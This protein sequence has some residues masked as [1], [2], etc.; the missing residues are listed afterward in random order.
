MNFTFGIVSNGKNYEHLNKCLE[1]IIN[2]KIK[3]SEIIVVGNLNKNEIVDNMKI[4]FIDFD[5]NIKPGWITRKK[6]IITENSKYENI[7]YLHDYLTF[8]KNWYKGFT[9]FGNNFEIS[10]NKILNPNNTRYRDWTLWPHND[11]FMDEIIDDNACLIPYRI[12]NLTEYMYI[13]GAYWVAKKEI[14][15]EFPLN[16]NLTWGEG[17]DVEWSKQVR[18]KYEFKFN[19]YSIVKLQK[20]KNPQFKKI[21]RAQLRSI[22]KQIN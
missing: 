15:K 16:E 9:K 11:C 2:Q 20:Y 13:S 1:S 10:M 17:E 12:K 19:K 8:H 18:Q 6:N 7:V 22:K 5:E 14:M 21:S 3:N 4:K